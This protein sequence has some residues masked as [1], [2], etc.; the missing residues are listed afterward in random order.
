MG[1]AKPRYK[2]PV[3]LDVSYMDME[4]TL[5]SKNGLGFQQPVPARI[6]FFSLLA[7]FL[8]MYS[9]TKT[10][11]ASGGF[12]NI[13]GFTICYA[14][15]MV[16]MIRQDKTRR[17]GFHL[18][19]AMSRYYPKSRRLIPVRSTDRVMEL[20]NTLHIADVDL[21]DGLIRFMDGSIGQCYHIVGSASALMFE[22]DK[23]MILDK[24]DS[25]YRKI[26]LD[27]ELIFD[28]VYEGHS[29]DEQL[30]ATLQVQ[31]N[32]RTRSK[33]LE[34]LLQERYDVLDKA[35]NQSE[36]LTSIHQYLII[37]AKN[38][39]ALTDVES[40]IFGDVEGDGVMFRLAKAAAHKEILRYLQ[41]I[42]NGP[43]MSD[44]RRVKQ[45]TAR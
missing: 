15:F 27:V 21:E 24:V 1:L 12:L 14:I 17:S 35:I 43:K 18:V 42:L 20:Q 38:E 16:L 26:G 45:R 3:S 34:K 4:F 33:G 22:Q 8:W 13:V 19:L 2:I 44:K 36:R 5:Q 39:S 10:F 40:L 9:V 11:I 25:F 7:M 30:D 29:V 32:L 23:Q 41:S 31:K 37:I 28:T 6:I